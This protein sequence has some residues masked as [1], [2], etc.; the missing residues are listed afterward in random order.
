MQP[1]KREISSLKTKGSSQKCRHCIP[2]DCNCRDLEI[3]RYFALFVI[4]CNSVSDWRMLNACGQIKIAARKWKSTWHIC[5][6][7]WNT[8]R[9]EKR[10]VLKTT[11][12]KSKH[13]EEM[14]VQTLHHHQ[15]NS[16]SRLQTI[17]YPKFCKHSQIYSEK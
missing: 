15:L 14:F 17:I 13:S 3:E 16:A 5:R 4:Y 8:E 6:L 10:C 11:R 9:L 12:Q 7:P 1:S 2:P